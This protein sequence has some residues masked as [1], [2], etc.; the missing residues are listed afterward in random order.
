MN[1]NFCL[2]VVALAIPLVL[3]ALLADLW[4]KHEL[5]EKLHKKLSSILTA[6]IRSRY[7]RKK[8]A[9]GAPRIEDRADVEEKREKA[10]EYWELLNSGVTKKDAVEIV[11][12]HHDVKTLDRWVEKLL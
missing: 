10:A 11:S 7:G 9:V 12:G 8:K 5:G 6:W 1:W 4:H 3:G 2:A